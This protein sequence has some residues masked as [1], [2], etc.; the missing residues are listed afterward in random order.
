MRGRP[1]G[2]VS[3]GM[4]GAKKR[5]SRTNPPKRYSC[6]DSSETDC[7]EEAYRARIPKKNQHYRDHAYYSFKRP[8]E[9][10]VAP[11]SSPSDRPRHT[12]AKSTPRPGTPVPSDAQMPT[13]AYNPA[14][15]PLV[16]MV[17]PGQHVSGHATPLP[18]HPMPSAPWPQQPP[19]PPSKVQNRQP[20]PCP[21]VGCNP[22][23][24]VFRPRFTLPA[25]H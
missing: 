6:S 19:P 16:I 12:R 21:G 13:P 17:P 23:A 22:R 2:K 24:P 3:P 7:D 15:K 10:P 1:S 14:N 25:L 5:K 8:W 11:P 4:T 18:Q 9:P 20:P